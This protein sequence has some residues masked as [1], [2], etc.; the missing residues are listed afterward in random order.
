MNPLKRAVFHGVAMILLF[1]A[2]VGSV[3]AWLATANPPAIGEITVGELSYA[4]QADGTTFAIELPIAEL[5]YVDLLDDV[6][7]NQSGMLEEV[8]TRMFL[9]LSGQSDTIPWRALLSI[10]S[11][12]DLTGLLPLWIFEGLNL[13][14]THVDQ[15]D[16]HGIFASL[17]LSAEA[18]EED[19]RN[20]IAAYNESVLESISLIEI[21]ETDEIRIQV[22]FWGDYDALTTPETF[23]SRQY[24][25]SIVI[26]VFQTEKEIDG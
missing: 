15:S 9:T 17:G 25:L 12:A 19:W 20:A 10:Q 23:L 7:D 6:R 13:D 18:T 1:G 16:Y 14:E 5:M 2:F 8:S 24:E 26:N 11:E 3:F 4:I 21:E 22:V